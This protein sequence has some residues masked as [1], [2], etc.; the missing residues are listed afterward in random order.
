MTYAIRWASLDGDGEHGYLKSMDSRA[1]A[2]AYAREYAR[3][4]AASFQDLG[5]VSETLV[6]ADYVIIA[7]SRDGHRERITVT[8]R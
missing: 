3:A 6:V 8:E 4:V 7:E 5:T 2:L 1:D